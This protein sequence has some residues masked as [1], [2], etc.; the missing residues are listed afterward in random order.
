MDPETFIARHP[1]LFH[2]A[3]AG[4][5]ESIKLRGL[6]ST[7][8]LLDLFEITGPERE[9]IESQRRP[10]IVTITHPSYDTAQI[11]DNKPLREQF[12]LDCLV[13][14]TPREFYE[15]LNHKVFFWVTPERLDTLIGARAYRDRPHD[16]ITIDTRLLLER[17]GERLAL[18]SIN[19]GATLYPNCP[20]RG[21]DTFTPLGSFDLAAAKKRRGNK[22]AIVE[23]VID[24]AVPD[25]AEL[26]TR[27]ERRESGRPN[28]TLA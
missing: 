21:A 27:V 7:T 8:A 10:E 16:V 25:I 12:L 15:L 1:R 4:A 20:A 24:Y 17:Y 5:W 19:T 18:A 6:R 9:R 11:R 14:M 13:G 22:D 2:M 23:A 28:I 26:V 3:E